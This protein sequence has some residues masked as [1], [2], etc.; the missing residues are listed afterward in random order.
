MKVESEN[1]GRQGRGLHKIP[2]LQ[3]RIHKT[4]THGL[5]NHHGKETS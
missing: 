1:K 5:E 2:Q 3:D 4:E